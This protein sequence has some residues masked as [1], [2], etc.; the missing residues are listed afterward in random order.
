MVRKVPK[1]SA[2]KLAFRQEIGYNEEYVIEN[3][4]T[5]HQD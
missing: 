1:S 4:G 5:Y 2:T 3:K